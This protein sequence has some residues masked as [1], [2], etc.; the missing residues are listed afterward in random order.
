MK[1]LL[2][3]PNPD[4]TG[5]IARWTRNVLIGL[6]NEEISLEIGLL[7]TTRKRFVHPQMFIPKRIFLGILFN[8]KLLVKYVQILGSQKL[9]LIHINTSGRFAFFR[10]LILLGLARCY[11]IKVV[12]HM[13][14]G[15]IPEIFEASFSIERYLTRAVVLNSDGIFVLDKKTL[16][17]L[18]DCAPRAAVYLI[19]NF[20]DSQILHYQSENRKSWDVIYAG[21]LLISKGLVEFLTAIETTNYPLNVCICGKENKETKNLIDKVI[22]RNSIHNISFY[23]EVNHNEIIKLIRNSRTLILPSYTEGFPNVVIEAMAQ[24]TI[25]IAT[26]VG[27]ISDILNFDSD[28]PLGLEIAIKSHQSI[29][30]QLDLVMNASQKFYEGLTNK[31]YQEVESKYTSDVVCKDIYSY[32]SDILSH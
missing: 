3:S 10:D 28:E 5:G 12:V 6:E 29:N 30:R 27:A 20:I 1:I 26:S 21:Q 9:D 11:N 2:I 32:W 22:A 23:G 4:S 13:H 19:P 17:S 8:T 18:R 14:F 16:R 25:V 31:A 15:R 7:S 24:K